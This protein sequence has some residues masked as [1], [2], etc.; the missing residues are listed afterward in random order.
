MLAEPEDVLR[1]TELEYARDLLCYP[2]N[3]FDYGE[4]DLHCARPA[5]PAKI[6]ELHRYWF[7]TGVPL[8]IDLQA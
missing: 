4:C 5:G 2:A 1:S 6:E 7:D 3:L 8:V